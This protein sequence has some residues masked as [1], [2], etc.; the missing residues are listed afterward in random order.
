[1][2]HQGG[3]RAARNA[4]GHRLG[5]RKLVGGGAARVCAK[6]ILERP[7]KDLMVGGEQDGPSGAPEQQMR[8][9]RGTRVE[10]EDARELERD[11]P[12]AAV[13]AHCE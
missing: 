4:D 2:E 13:L 6:D 11:R 12:D 3:A 9:A 1:M 10:A 8:R 5:R 7:L